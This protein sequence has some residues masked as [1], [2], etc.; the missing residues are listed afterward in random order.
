M[1][2]Q[3]VAGERQASGVGPLLGLRS[4]EAL[5][6]LGR[7]LPG[8]EPLVDIGGPDLEGETELLEELPT[9]RRSRGEDESWWPYEI[10]ALQ[11]ILLSSLAE[12][13]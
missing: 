4:R 10:V 7:A 6:G 11:S 8:Q 9:T 1:R 3:R 12:F 2:D 5:R 13:P